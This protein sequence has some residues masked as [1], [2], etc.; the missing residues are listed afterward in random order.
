MSIKFFCATLLAISCTAS[1]QAI[2]SFPGAEGFGAEASGGRGGKVVFVTNLENSGSGS[3]RSALFGW[4]ARTIVFKVGGEIKLT[5]PLSISGSNIT[6][7]GQTAPDGGITLRG[8]PLIISGSN[9]II[10][11]IRVRHGNETGRD[12]D[13]VSIVDGASKIILDHV[14][15]SW[16]ID[17]TLSPSGYIKDITLQ[18]CLISESLNNSGHKKGSHGYG[19]LLR[20]VGGVSLHHNLWAHHRGRNPRFGDNYGKLFNDAPTFD[21]RNNVIYDWGDYATGM[22]DGDIRVNY[23]ANFLKPGPSSRSL[24][25]VT[26]TTYANEKTRFFTADN[27]IEAHPEITP[28]SGNFFGPEAGK[29]TGNITHV[30]EAFVTPQLSTQSAAEAYALVLA[31]AGASVPLRDA[32]DVRVIEQ[33]RSGNGRLIDTQNDVGGWPVLPAGIAPADTDED[34]IPDDWEL[35]YGLNPKDAKDGGTLSTSGYTNLELYLNELAERAI[36]ALISK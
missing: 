34:G 9:L 12:D 5:S 30:K 29:T 7:A 25:P 8:H 15:A 32:V 10:R 19:S 3:L 11:F 6:I 17:E 24:Q 33:V 36:T 16:S 18:W 27:V 35:A 14:S 20:A 22:V 31:H 23:V 21:F 13:A 2:P 28:A 4:G 26:L 1:A